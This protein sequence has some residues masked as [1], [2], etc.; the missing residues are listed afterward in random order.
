MNAGS[1]GLPYEGDGAAR[2]LWIEDGEPELRV[3]EYD[4]LAAGRRMVEA[5]WDE[6][7]ISASLLEPLP[8]IEI[9]R[10]FEERSA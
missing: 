5:G 10:M 7:S 6:E 4:S 2:W 8:A 9:T 1:V 3:T